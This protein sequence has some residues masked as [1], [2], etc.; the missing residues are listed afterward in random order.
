V[1]IEAAEGP[2]PFMNGR[3]ALYQT[4]GG[5][6]HLSFWTEQHGEGHKDFPPRLV[7]MMSSGKLSKMFGTDG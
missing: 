7:K 6:M 5:G 3:F 1:A 2:T 4:P